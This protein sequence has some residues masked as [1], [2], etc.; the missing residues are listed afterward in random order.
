VPL[1]PSLRQLVPV[2]LALAC[3]SP[4]PVTSADAGIDAAPPPTF[5]GI[6]LPDDSGGSRLKL[7]WWT[8]STGVSVPGGITDT[9]LGV[10]C[11]W[12]LFEGSFRC[13]PRRERPTGYSDPDCT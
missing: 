2:I 3:H 6:T 5:P 1:V 10:G 7:G 8:A 4:L 13:L 12:A 11:S 9:A